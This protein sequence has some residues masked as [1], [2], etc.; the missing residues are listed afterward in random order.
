MTARHPYAIVLLDIKMPD[1][2]GMEVLKRIR[3]ENP[4]TE[5]IMI[6][7]FPTIQGAVE[8]IKHG[9]LDLPGETFPHRRLEA[10]GSK[11]PG[12]TWPR[13]TKE[14][15]EAELDR[16]GMEFI[17]GDSRPCRRF[18]QDP[19]CRAPRQHRAA[20]RE[21]GT[22]KELAARAIHLLSP[23][24]DKNS[25]RWTA[26]PWWI[27]A[28]KRTLRPRQG[29]LHGTPRPSTASSNWPTTAPF[30]SMKSPISASTSRPNSPGDPG[31]GVHAVGSQKRIKLDIRIIASSNRTCTRLSRAA[32]FGKTSSTVSASFPSIC[33]RSGNGRGTF[34]SWRSIFCA[35]TARRPTGR[36]VGFPPRTQAA[37]QLCLARQRPELEH[38]IERIVILEDG[39]IIQPEHLPSL[40]PSARGSSRSSPTRSIPWK[41]WRNATFN[42]SCAAP[43]APP[44]AGPYPRIIRKTLSTKIEKIQPAGG[45]VGFKQSGRDQECKGEGG[46]VADLPLPVD[47][48]AAEEFVSPPKAGS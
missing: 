6:T 31:A 40:F 17:I 47:F 33:R 44:D 3:Q 38:T 12:Q 14:P 24:R 46:P 8:C 28:G 25:C 13:R 10:V 20:Y 4:A 27:P 42:S 15:D 32:S 26:P 43:R 21:S 16:D 34:P 1:L 30:S 11:G 48:S 29:L 19:A 18:C 2:N 37:E 22:G 35:N 23:R 41:T 9:A 45:L 7:G 5:I 39:D 36:S